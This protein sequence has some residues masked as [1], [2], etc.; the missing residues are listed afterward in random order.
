MVYLMLTNYFE[1]DIIYDDNSRRLHTVFG[2]GARKSVLL[3]VQ[4][5]ASFARLS[6][7]EFSFLESIRTFDRLIVF[8]R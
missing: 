3:P 5:V 1:Y 8:S 6:Q 7:L 2:G 4:D